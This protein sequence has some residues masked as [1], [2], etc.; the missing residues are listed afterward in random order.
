MALSERQLDLYDRGKFI[1]AACITQTES[2]CHTN[3]N[4][5]VPG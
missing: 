3:Y 1:S 5:A 4:Q 2:L